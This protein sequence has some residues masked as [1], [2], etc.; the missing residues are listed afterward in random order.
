MQYQGESYGKGFSYPEHNLP[1][2]KK[3]ADWCMQYAR[4]AYYDWNNVYPKGCMSNNLGEYEKFRMYSLGKQPVN[5]YKKL[6][7]VDQQTNQ[8]WLTIDWSVRAIVSTYRDRTI[9]ELMKE[10][11]R[12][13]ASPV[14]MLAK[15]ELDTYLAQM[16]AKI[17]V[18]DLMMKQNPELASHP[19]LM[20]KQG[21]PM[22]FEELEMRLQMN[23]QFNRSEDAE[24]AIELG[25]YENNYKAI[26]LQWLKDFFD[27]GVAG[28]KEW[29]GDDNKPKAKA[30]DPNNIVVSY[31]EDPY[32]RDIVHAGEV[33]DVSLMELAMLTNEDGGAL[34]DEKEL[35]EFAS[36]VAGKWG[37]PFNFNVG[38]NWLT[39]TDKFKCKIF[40]IYFYTYNDQQYTTRVGKD[41]NLI[42]KV[43]DELRG[44]KNNPKYQRK[45][46]QYVYKCNWI[47][48][49]DK[50]YNWGM[51]YDQKRSN[52]IKKKAL[53]KLPYRFASF[54]FYKM[55]AQG[56]MERLIPLLDSYQLTVY[57]IQNFKNR[58]V[59]SG[60]WID[61]NALESVALNKGG[62]N[63]TP[64]ELLQ[65]FFETG[66]LIGR[67]EKDNGE[68]RSQNWKPVI[69]IENTAAS[70]LA[71]F[72]QDL[73]MTIQDIERVVGF[74]DITAGN[75]NP[76]TLV[77]GYE[78]A[79]NSTKNSIFPIAQAEEYLTLC[80]SEDILARTQ[81]G[82][83]KAGITGYAPALGSNVLKFIELSG[84]MALREYGII[85]EK[86]MTDEQ[87][88][89]LLQQM[90]IDIQNQLL[91]SV[92][93]AI[94]LNTRN[95][96]QAMQIWA[97]RVKKAKQEAQQNQLQQIQLNNQGQQQA[98]QVAQQA[99]MQQMQMQMQFELQK[100][101]NEI[102][103]E[104]KLKQ[105]ELE[106]EERRSTETNLTKIQV[107]GDQA[108][109][110]VLGHQIAS[111]SE[112]EKA[113]VAGEKAKEKQEIA[114]EK[115]VSSSK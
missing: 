107:G 78:I 113:H 108:T 77:P 114:N 69:P 35:Q 101:Q 106:S 3:D 39:Q 2:S 102:M 52:D 19:L 13:I 91:S 20:A 92:D 71:M 93:A 74:N 57:K 41:G 67:S 72:Y 1:P 65:M 31:T 97:Y 48:G 88:M 50:C 99:T 40:E 21:E 84:D 28:Y 70:E 115:P 15:S 9:S 94:L 22:D 24:M 80:L 73:I 104:L 5:Q 23:E 59:P 34:F 11:Y 7:G 62:K 76:K 95:L 38:V 26:R 56:F 33:C 53:T 60:W 64:K 25:M 49:T 12:I 17:A 45:R 111:A 109:A 81:Q 14:D 79:N 63:M 36:S 61:L 82:L 68:P 100:Q 58:A 42:F 66:V 18:R 86:K 6:M 87:K 46:I 83:K 16:K 47:I 112:I 51:C 90:S 110:K 44:G 98:A 10:D 54:N 8:T 43:E 37:N 89:W 75:P 105:M 103:K 96:K 27:T 55:R 32:F 4:A 29:L 30:V 85:L